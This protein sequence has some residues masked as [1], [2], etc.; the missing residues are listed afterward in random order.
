LTLTLSNDIQIDFEIDVDVNRDRER[1]ID[2][3][4]GLYNRYRNG[5]IKPITLQNQVLPRLIF[6]DFGPESVLLLVL[7]LF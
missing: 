2:N 5:N 6:V 7:V 1:D 4:I 3:A